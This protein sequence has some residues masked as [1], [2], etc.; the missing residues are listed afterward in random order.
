MAKPMTTT[1]AEN[2]L[3]A[4]PTDNITRMTMTAD[5]LVELHREEGQR[6]FVAYLIGSEENG[7]DNWEGTSDANK[8]EHLKRQVAAIH[9]AVAVIR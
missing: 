5:E 6:G 8:A 2:L 7:V 4:L 3:R 9:R 1:A